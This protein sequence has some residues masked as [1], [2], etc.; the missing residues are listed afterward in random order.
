MAD[1]SFQFIVPDCDLGDLGECRRKMIAAINDPALDQVIDN[2][3]VGQMAAASGPTPRGGEASV[4]GEV[5]SNG[6]WTVKGEVKV[7]W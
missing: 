4:T 3:R 2:L 6:D 7:T 1:T 5:K